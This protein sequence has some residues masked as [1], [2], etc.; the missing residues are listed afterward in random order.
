VTVAVDAVA[1]SGEWIRHAP[2]HSDLLGRAA[3][4]TDGRWQRGAV[5][6]A[7]YLADDAATAAAEWYRYL[8]ERG[9]PPTSAIPH[10]HHVWGIE[11]E[12]ADLSDVERLAA[13]GLEPPRPQRRSWPPYQHIGETLFDEGWRGL[14]AP[15]AARPDAVV[16]CIFENGW[17]PVGCLPLRAIEITHAP[18][19]PTGM[20]T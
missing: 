2:H 14:L 9:V 15:S 4:A 5:V 6:Q 10:D 3:E 20:T 11:L 13:V 12:V 16:L 8:A 17:P 19:P 18:P 1:V 7:L